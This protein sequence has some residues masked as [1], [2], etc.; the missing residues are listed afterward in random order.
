M[1]IKSSRRKVK[2]LNR[3]FPPPQKK[4]KIRILTYFTFM[5]ERFEKQ[6]LKSVCY[7]SFIQKWTRAQAL[8]IREGGVKNI[9]K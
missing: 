1:K 4:K 8:L 3:E 6:Y 5:S 7:K 2:N 9:D